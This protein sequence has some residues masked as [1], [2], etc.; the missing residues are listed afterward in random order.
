MLRSDR[1]SVIDGSLANQPTTQHS[2]SNLVLPF[3]KAF[4]VAQVGVEAQAIPKVEQPVIHVFQPR[5]LAS[6]F[7][8]LL[9]LLTPSLPLLLMILLLLILLLLPRRQHLLLLLL[10]SL[11]LL[12]LILIVQSVDSL[13]HPVCPSVDTLDCSVDLDESLLFPILHEVW[14]LVV[15]KS[16]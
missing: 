8:H 9:L 1:S 14:A 11:L 4:H 13:H 15:P 2:L 12:L 6:E 5:Q 3:I 10:L 7:R 16:A